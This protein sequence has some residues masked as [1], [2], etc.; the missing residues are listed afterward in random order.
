MST[1]SRIGVELSNGKVKSVYC[2]ND[3]YIDG[4]GNELKRSITN[5]EQAEAFVDEGDRTTV[6]MS[7][8]EWRDEDV[9]IQENESVES[10]FK[11]DTEEYGYLFTQDEEWIVSDHDRPPVT[12]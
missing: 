3:G 11:G 4:V 2:H 9:V 1:R 12:F 6:G 5:T 7:Y 8:N 10:F